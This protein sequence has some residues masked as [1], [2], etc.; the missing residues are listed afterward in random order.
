MKKYYVQVVS[1][2]YGSNTGKQL[3]LLQ[4]SLDKGW[5]IERADATNGMIVYVLSKEK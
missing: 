1:N 5:E 3:D 4:V 2:E